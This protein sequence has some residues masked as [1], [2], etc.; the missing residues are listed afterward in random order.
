[1]KSGIDFNNDG[2]DG[3]TSQLL[4]EEPSNSLNFILDL[5]MRKKPGTSFNYNDG[6]PQIVSA[7]I[8]KATG[9]SLKEWTKENLLD[10]IGIK[11]PGC[12]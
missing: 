2:F 5:D 3:E 1:M 10:K 12:T 7:V 4:R 6:D 11:P 9:K 8:Q